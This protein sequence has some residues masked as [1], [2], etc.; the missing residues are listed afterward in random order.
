LSK[1]GHTAYAHTSMQGW[2][3]SM[4]DSHICIPNLALYPNLGF[5][6]VM[7]GHGGAEVAEFLQSKLPE[8]LSEILENL[9][10][11]QKARLAKICS[12]DTTDLQQLL[13]EILHHVFMRTDMELLNEKS[14]KKMNRLIQDLD[15]KDSSANSGDEDELAELEMEACLSVEEL[16]KKYGVTVEKADYKET[17]IEAENNQGEQSSSKKTVVE[18]ENGEEKVSSTGKLFSLENDFEDDS[19]DDSEELSG[20][21]S[22]DNSS[23]SDSADSDNENN[24]NIS[25]K[26]KSQAED[27]LDPE[28][29]LKIDPKKIHQMDFDEEQFNGTSKFERAG[30]DSGATAVMS[31]ITSTGLLVVANAGD[32][33]CSVGRKRIIVKEKENGHNK[34]KTVSTESSN[35][36]TQSSHIA[37]D[38]SIDHKPED[39]NELQRILSAG[40]SL[41]A[42]GRVDGGLNLSRSLGDHCYKKTYT[43]PLSRQKISPKP[44]IRTL[45]LTKNDDFIV[46]ACDGIWNVMSSQAVTDFIA[47]RIEKM[48]LKEITEELLDQ[49]LAPDTKGDGT[50][51]DN[52][53]VVIVRLCEEFKK[54]AV[55]CDDL[56]MSLLEENIEKTD[57]ECPPVWDESN[58][59]QADG[60]A[61]KIGKLLTEFTK[62][63]Y[64]SENKDE[65]RDYGPFKTQ[66]EYKK[67][68]PWSKRI[69]EE[70][71]S[72]QKNDENSPPSKKVKVC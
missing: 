10:A 70:D 9:N 42:D 41:S 49:C 54:S 7:D 5:F 36:E 71:F 47:D 8:V 33:R 26:V 27:D 38:M 31:I 24:S 17:E 22:S 30:V 44:D 18:E 66:K 58:T 59:N 23:G 55:E 6:G 68:N 16:A 53:T 40:G 28:Q 48:E 57:Q 72:D 12:N 21:G 37:I 62:I 46:I 34:E 29:Y 1:S 4:E 64:L 15:S 45:Q 19:E 56:D 25:A 14:L 52:M 67:E 2:R 43:L 32:S 39:P 35:G 65:E 11:E 20:E 61:Q 63:D 3:T 69:L 51:C 50:G 60:S 13:A